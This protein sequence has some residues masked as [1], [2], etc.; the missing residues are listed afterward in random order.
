MF[1]SP[2]LLH[3]VEEAFN[4]NSYITELKLDGI[5][6]LLTKFNSKVRLYTRHN[7][8]VTSLFPELANIQLPD[9][10]VLDGELIVTDHEGKPD[11]EAMMERFKS[12]RSQH[13][14]SFSVFDILYY[15]NDKTYSLPLLDRKELI[16]K[17]I[18]E[19]TIL[20]NKVKWIEGNAIQYF[21]AVK[22][23]DLEGI[24]IK[25]SDSKY[26]PQTRSHNWL[27]V[28]NYKFEDVYITG[29]RK[30]EFGLVLTFLNGQYAGVMEFMPL[31]AKKEF[32]RMFR[33]YVINENDSAWTLKPGIKIN[34]KYR[35][36]TKKGL[37]RIPSFVEWL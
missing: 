33:D 4:D 31:D 1:I 8:E 27:K 18:K 34:V 17:V 7:N 36:L 21:D 3:R 11:F 15:K 9:G 24:V 22:Q 35:N 19:D 37:L 6:L 20:I 14:I 25:K 5:R 26:K 23:R 32:Y 28:I 29:V 12:K 16:N 10:I 2:M 30:D 13:Q